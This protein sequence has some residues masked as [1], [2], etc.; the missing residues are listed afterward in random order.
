VNPNTGS[1]RLIL[2]SASPRRVEL[3]RAAGIECDVKP[4][5]VDE[6]RLPDEL[7]EQY[8]R[9]LAG[10]KA[11][12]VAARHPDRPVL[13][14]DTVVVVG[15]QLLGKPE[16]RDDAARMLRLLAGRAHE[17]FTGVALMWPPGRIV[18]SVVVTTVEL[19]ALGE[20]ELAWYVATGEGADKA[21]GYGVQGLASRFVKRVSGSYSSVVGLPVAEVYRLLRETDLWHY[22][23]RGQWGP[24][25]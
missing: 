14:A 22:P 13:G 8:V 19:A 2:A 7:P 17:V 10:S 4:A 16:N 25:P 24:S 12:A 18:T 11:G 5:A 21:G 1:P 15:E 9:R 20:D 6:R 3:A 23:V